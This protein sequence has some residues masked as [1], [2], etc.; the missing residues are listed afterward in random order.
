MSLQ[1]SAAVRNAMLD[2]IETASGTTAIV[3]IFTSTMPA[4]TV[5]ASAGSPLV[6][7]TLASDWAA[8]A[9][10]GSKAFSATPLQAS[11]IATGTAGYFRLFDSTG[12]TCHM[13]GT[14]TLTGGGGDM[15]LDNTSINSGQAVQI[16][17]WTLT[18]PGA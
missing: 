11:A 6:S 7:W 16:T 14:V 17:S 12:T 15:T 10:G 9:S 2:A 4:S 1:F 18:A 3:K 13:Q 5:T 8:A